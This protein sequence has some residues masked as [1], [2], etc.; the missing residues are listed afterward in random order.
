MTGFSEV[1][2]ALGAM[3][4]SSQMIGSFW[5]GAALSDVD[6]NALDPATN[7]EGVERA[8]TAEVRARAIDAALASLVMVDKFVLIELKVCRDLS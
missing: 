1:P 6:W 8:E 3:T 5:S 4:D 7:A 2:C